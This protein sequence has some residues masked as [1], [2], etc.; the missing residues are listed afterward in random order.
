MS[1]CDDPRRR[2]LVAVDASE[3]AEKAFYCM[4]IKL[5]V[6]YICRSWSVIPDIP[7]CDSLTYHINYPKVDIIIEKET[8]PR[9]SV[10]SLS[11]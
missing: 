8:N 11:Q 1:E 3:E 10:A 9:Y 2:I 4:Y 5:L 7:Y 6:K